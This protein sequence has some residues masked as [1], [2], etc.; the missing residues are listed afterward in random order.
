MKPVDF[1]LVNFGHVIIGAEQRIE[2]E[3]TEREAC[4]LTM[5]HQTRTYN[6]SLVNVLRSWRVRTRLVRGCWSVEA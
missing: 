3:S 2:H 1:V 5:E 6:V 4:R